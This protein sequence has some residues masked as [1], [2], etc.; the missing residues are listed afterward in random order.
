MPRSPRFPF[1]AAALL[2]AAFTPLARAQTDPVP[3]Q[4]PQKTHA[5]VVAEL[6]QAYRAGTV[7]SGDGDYPPSDATVAAN[8]A[9]IEAMPPPWVRAAPGNR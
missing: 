8:R 1:A 9:R 3:A 2:L 5:Q 4:A 6:V 7:P